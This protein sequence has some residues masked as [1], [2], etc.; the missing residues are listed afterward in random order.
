MTH[1]PGSLHERSMM[2]WHDGHACKHWRLFPGVLLFWSANTD[3]METGSLC[4]SLKALTWRCGIT[5]WPVIWLPG[6]LWWD[7]ATSPK[8]TWY[9]LIAW[10]N[11]KKEDTLETQLH[12]C[13]LDFSWGWQQES[14]SSDEWGACR[15]MNVRVTAKAG[16][17]PEQNVQGCLQAEPQPVPGCVC[18]PWWMPH[19]PDTQA[20]CL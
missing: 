5:I 14:L 17:M 7:L 4:H 8:G 15:V 9:Q 6:D 11:S 13:G 16:D 18:L 3:F 20:N 10:N 12:N 19:P 1:S 2:A